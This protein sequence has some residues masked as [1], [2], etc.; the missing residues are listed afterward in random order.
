MAKKAFHGSDLEL[1]EQ[2]YGIPKDQ[3]VSFSSNVNPIGISYK[4]KQS[5][6]DNVDMITMYPDRECTDLRQAL[7]EYCGAPMEQIQVGSGVTELI[8]M[9]IETV[10]PKKALLIEPTYSEYE[11]VI[12][13][14]GGNVFSFPVEERDEFRLNVDKLCDILKDAYDLL[15]ICNPNNPTGTAVKQQ[16]LRKIFSHCKKHNIFV[17]VD[18]TYVE[19]AD[20][21]EEITAIPLVKEF[22]NIFVMRGISKFFAAPGLRIGYMVNSNKEVRD[23][24]DRVKNPWTLNTLAA[25]CG[26][27]MFRDQEFIDETRRFM[28][29][30]KKRLLEILKG[31]PGLK[32][33]EPTANFILMKILNPDVTSD[34]IFE[35]CIKD[36]LMIRDCSSFPGFGSEYIRFCICKPEENTRLMEK[37]GEI[38][39]A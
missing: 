22:D 15:V 26:A 29:S 37:L 36:G 1:I 35:H 28:T 6:H 2:E 20:E 24:I 18:E 8:S 27:E 14:N 30:E 11:R 34:M 32:V 23:Y 4:L 25:V 17:M 38:M 39:G 12:K 10:K 33:Y 13:N 16:E 19:F 21:L 7:S 3:I 5:I 9:C 31:I